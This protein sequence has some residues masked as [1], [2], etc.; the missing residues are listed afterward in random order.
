MSIINPFKSNKPT[1]EELIKQQSKNQQEAVIYEQNNQQ[2]GIDEQMFLENREKFAELRRWQQDLSPTLKQFFLDLSGVQEQEDGKL[3]A[4]EGYT[5][6]CNL[7]GARRIVNFLKPIDKNV[8]LGN[9]EKSVI[10]RAA[11]DKLCA[12]VN[13]LGKNYSLYGIKKN[14]ADLTVI[15]VM[16]T[17]FVH[18]TYIRGWNNGERNLDGKIHKSVETNALSPE[19]PSKTLFGI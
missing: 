17:D 3:V 4:V 19:K 2:T 7:T 6:H 1:D 13:D 5:P 10:Q 12:F 8:M 15:R 14:Y 11:E 16:V 18:A 9:W